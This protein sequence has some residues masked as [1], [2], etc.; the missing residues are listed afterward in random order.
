MAVGM[1]TV[2]IDPAI[3]ARARRRRGA[4]YVFERIEPGKTALLAIDLQNWTLDRTSPTYIPNAESLVSPVNAVARALRAAGG[5]V[6]WVQME[7][8]EEAQ[9]QWP[10]FY[11]GIVQAARMSFVSGMRPGSHWHELYPLLDVRPLDI[12]SAKTRYSCM[13]DCSSDLAATLHRM[14]VDTVLVAGVSTNV[15]CESTARDAMMM[16]YRVI[17]LAD[18]CGCRSDQE[19]NASLSNLMNM[20]ADVR[21]CESVIQMLEVDG[22]APGEPKHVDPS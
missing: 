13:L 16:N 19:H 12:V 7:A 14:G 10:V 18:G 17:V 5:T 21:S 9:K 11:D 4:E 3:A 22:S 20:F 1:H 6:V 8:S 2:W 15:C